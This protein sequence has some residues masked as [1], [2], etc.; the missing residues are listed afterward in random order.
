MV[1]PGERSVGLGDGSARG[2]ACNPQHIVTIVHAA[3]KS[4][5]ESLTLRRPD[6]EERVDENYRVCE[7]RRGDR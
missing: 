7:G 3:V 4:L 5:H 1:L 6:E 2:V